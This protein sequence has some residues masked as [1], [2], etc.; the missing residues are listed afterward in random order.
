MAAEDTFTLLP[1]HLDPASK[2]ITSTGPTDNELQA[3][4]TQLNQLH[5]ALLTLDNPG[6][7]PPPPLPV[8]PKRGAQVAKLRDTGNTAFRKAQY[9]DA[10]RIYSLAIDMALGRPGWEPAGLVRDEVSGLYANRA[11][12]YMG[13]QAWAEGAVDAECSVEIRKVGNAKAWWR[14]G[15]C[16]VE[17]GRLDEAKGWVDRALEFDGGEQDLVAL[18]KE[19]QAALERKK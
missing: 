10:I 1:L 13:M 18:R 4:L 14:R 5:R 12:A 9:A 2:A 19:I 6:G 3:E 17:M 11:Q 7:V 16:L 15:R 8:N